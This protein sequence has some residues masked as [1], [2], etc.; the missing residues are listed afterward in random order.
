MKQKLLKI[1]NEDVD[2]MIFIKWGKSVSSSNN[3]AFVSNAVIG[4]IFGIDGSSVRRLYMKR[5]EQLKEKSI[6]TRK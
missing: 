5:F 3:P 2:N 4:K 1:T 6:M